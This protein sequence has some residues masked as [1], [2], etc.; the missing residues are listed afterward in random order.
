MEGQE[1]EELKEQEKHDGWLGQ[2][3][4]NEQEKKDGGLGAGGVVETGEA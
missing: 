2:E 3:E 4:Q 1:Q